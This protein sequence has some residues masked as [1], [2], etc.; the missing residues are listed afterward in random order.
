VPAVSSRAESN[1][2]IAEAMRDLIA[3]AV[4]TN[5]GIARSYGIHVVD[6]QTLGLI[7]RMARA[8]TPT[9]IANMTGL[10][11]STV[12][13]VVN[14]LEAA[15]FVRRSPDPDD[16][17]SVIVTAI[18]GAIESK[19]KSDPYADIVAALDR[20][21]ATFTPAELDVVARYLEGMSGTA[22]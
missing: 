18:A 6:L 7:L 1:G 17:R 13:R 9:E 5:E 20:H 11:T 4:L 15:G 21:N 22:R 16:R 14:R 2:R 19:S 8:V 12:T 3:N 10:P